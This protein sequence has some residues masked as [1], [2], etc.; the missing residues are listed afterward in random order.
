MPVTK[1]PVEI[2][3]EDGD[4]A[5]ET[6]TLWSTTH[7]TV[8]RQLIDLSATT[9]N[10]TF[11][12]Y[13]DLQA[14]TIAALREAQAL[15]L[16]EQIDVQELSKDPLAWYQKRVLET[17]DGAQHAFKR[18][19]T[20]GQAVTGSAERLHRSTEQA[21]KQIQAAF[22]GLGTQLKDVYPPAA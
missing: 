20:V 17:I 16:A 15:T 9:A 4:K 5:V 7:Q 1:S 3:R 2:F 14:S 12:L 22:T 13:S 19:E 11:K 6:L 21:G 8:L 18:V 10:E